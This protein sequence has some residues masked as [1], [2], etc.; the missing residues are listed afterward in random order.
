MPITPS[1]MRLNPPMGTHDPARRIRESR[2]LAGFTLAEIIVALT[3][4]ALLAAVLLPT[5]AGQILK[6]DASRVVQDLN[7]VRAG[8]E[9]FVADVHR[10]PGKYSDLSKLITT[11]NTDIL[12]STY[13]SGL[14]ARWSGPYVTKDTLS[15][16]IETGFGGNIQNT[17]TTIT[18]TN[19]ISYLT[20]VVVG[21][22]A[23]DFD[24]VDEVVDGPS[25]SPAGRTS[26]L[27]RFVSNVADSTRFLA[28]PIQ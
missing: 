19:N 2:R 13:P 6:G 24:K 11:S 15:A 8:A 12:G 28:V 23:N 25:V 22:S 14:V 26:G 21:I 27:L 1:K 10:Y 4:I 5:V 16:V 18:H 9:Q 3:L 7:A 20:V 17:F